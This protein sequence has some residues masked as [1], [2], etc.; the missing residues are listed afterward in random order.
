MH[1]TDGVCPVSTGHGTAQSS[2]GQCGDVAEN[3]S[4]RILLVDDS[5]VNLRVL[6]I[7]LERF[8]WCAPDTALS[9]REALDKHRAQPF[10]IILMDCFMPDMDGFAAAGE[11][12]RHERDAAHT[13]IIALTAN[14]A[15]GDR[16]L[17]LSAGMDDYLAKP[18]Q[19][20]RM[21]QM[22]EKWRQ[23]IVA[24]TAC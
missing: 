15:S 9:G 14:A 4:M 13:I 21:Q 10:D 6:S 18:I 16:E 20:D 23:R 12:R 7:M 17:C 24:G 2:G 8:G 19:V 22:L 3:H 11:I 1:G 5:P